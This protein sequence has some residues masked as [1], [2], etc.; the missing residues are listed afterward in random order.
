MIRSVV[1][2]LIVLALSSNIVMAL[3]GPA[4]DG[5]AMGEYDPATGQIIVSATNIIG[6]FV[7]YTL[8]DVMTGDDASGLPVNG[9]LVTDHDTRIGEGGLVSFSFTNLNLGNVAQTGLPDDGNLRIFWSP[10]LG[11][12]G[13]SQPLTF[14]SGVIND[15]PLADISGPYVVD[16]INAPLNITLG[17]QRFD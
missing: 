14:A 5:V 4:P 8:A 10:G 15:T 12:T 9:G 3:P 1:A 7:E 16:L 17:C 11:Q 2:V 6:W 13:L